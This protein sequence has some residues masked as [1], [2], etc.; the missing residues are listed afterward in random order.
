[1]AKTFCVCVGHKKS[2]IV[3]EKISKLDL[4]K[5]RNSCSLKD[6]VTQMKKQ[7]TKWENISAK[8]KCIWQRT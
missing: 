8:Q 5:M 3:N 7:A 4:I 1:M 6:T 2:Q